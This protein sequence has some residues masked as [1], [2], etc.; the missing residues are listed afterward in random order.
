MACT[1]M[2]GGIPKDCSNNLG[3][4]Q[5]IL[6]TDKENVVSTTEV[7]GEITAITMATGEV[8][9]EFV[10]NRNTSSFT[11][12]ATV[13]IENGTLFYNQV[14]S[15]VIPRRDK[16]KRAALALLMQKDLSVI[17]QDQNDKY[18]LLGKQNGLLVSE[19]VSGSGTAKT[20]LN[21]YT[22]TLTGEEPEQAPEVSSSIIAGLV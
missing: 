8:Y 15:L 13:G 9:Y 20:D 1:L 2:T 4:I 16:T 10:F 5:K 21:G 6:V 19:I 17:V 3:G 12:T 14:V 7:G 11:D 18:W 22:I